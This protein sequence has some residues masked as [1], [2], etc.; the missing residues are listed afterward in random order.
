MSQA[1][2]SAVHTTEQTATF[3]ALCAQQ[4]T[5]THISA[6]K[7]GD[8]VAQLILEVIQTPEVQEVEELPETVRGAGGYGSTGVS[9][10]L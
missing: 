6:V 10:A 8:R 9:V 5:I 2:G 1:A 3:V 7:R 4:H